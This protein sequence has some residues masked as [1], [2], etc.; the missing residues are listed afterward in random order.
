MI[1]ACMAGWM[2][3][4]KAE[5]EETWE[6]G[7]TEVMTTSTFK[8]LG[9]R[10]LRNIWVGRRVQLFATPWTATRLLCPQNSS[11]K[12]I[13]V[14]NHSLLQGNLPNPGIELWSPAQLVAHHRLEFLERDPGWT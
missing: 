13:G 14:S 10:G 2:V 8:V 4:P 9:V 11:S 7:K 5:M 12:N 1:P 3:M 6:E